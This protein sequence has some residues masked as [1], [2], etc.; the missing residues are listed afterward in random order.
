MARTTNDDLKAAFQKVADK[1]PTF[2]R[3]GIGL[4]LV[5]QRAFEPGVKAALVHVATLENTEWFVLIDTR[6][7]KHHAR[8]TPKSH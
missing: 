8:N 1:L 5:S 6:K 4:L 2:S 7:R 3:E